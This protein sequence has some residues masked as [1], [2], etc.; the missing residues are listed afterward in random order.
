MSPTVKWS[1][2]SH[3]GLTFCRAKAI[4]LFSSYFKTLSICQAL[5][6]KRSTTSVKISAFH[7]VSP[8]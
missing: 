3:K 8:K 6:V 7:P 1:S 5:E 4:P 2:E